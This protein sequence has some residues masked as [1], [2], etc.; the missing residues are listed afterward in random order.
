MKKDIDLLI[1]EAEKEEKYFQNYLA[2]AKQIKGEAEKLLGEVKVFVFG[3][4]LR[5]GEVARDI[6]VLIISPK[7]TKTSQKSK[8]LTEVREKIGLF[9]PF[10]L[11][12][13]SPEEYQN[14]YR[15]FLKEKVEI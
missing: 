2:Y 3:S 1:E 15:Y 6:D 9:S 10:E 13:V 8:T 5:K 12:L 14:W 7:L 4:V 11:H